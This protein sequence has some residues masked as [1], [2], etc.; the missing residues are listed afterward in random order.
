MKINIILIVLYYLYLSQLSPKISLRL[1]IE[2]N[3]NQPQFLALASADADFPQLEHKDTKRSDP[4][5]HGSTTR[6]TTKKPTTSSP[7]KYPPNEYRETI[8]RS[9]SSRRS[10]DNSNDSAKSETSPQKTIVV[11]ASTIQPRVTTTTTRSS[12]TR[13]QNHQ[14]NHQQ[15]SPRHNYD[16]VLLTPQ[17]QYLSTL[18]KVIITASAS[19]S[20]ASGKKLN[21]SVG[22]V[23]GPNIKIPP[24]NYDEYKEEDV[25]TDPFFLDVPKIKP[26]RNVRRSTT[27]A[28]TETTP[29]TTNLKK[30]A[31]HRT[32]R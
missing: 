18:P 9:S 1:P 14:Q 11:A 17:D 10:S 6:S 5:A 24:P 19:V 13:S 20:D 32:E 27:V 22:N 8:S 26:R 21:Y 30:V 15:L 16:R 31:V 28:E 4:H 2:H 3:P 7:S 25:S 12:R 23:I 29:L